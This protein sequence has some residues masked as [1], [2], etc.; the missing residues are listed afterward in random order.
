MPIWL[1]VYSSDDALRE[2]DAEM[3]G[4]FRATDLHRLHEFTD[5]QPSAS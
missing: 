3:I 2:R 5:I 1:P 4:A